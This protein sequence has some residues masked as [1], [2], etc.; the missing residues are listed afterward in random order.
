MEEIDKEEVMDGDAHE[1]F[2]IS[3]ESDS[4]DPDS[5]TEEESL[6]PTPEVEILN[7]DKSVTSISKKEE[8]NMFFH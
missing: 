8:A 4:N 2:L 3:Y 5:D 1:G 7:D 6:I